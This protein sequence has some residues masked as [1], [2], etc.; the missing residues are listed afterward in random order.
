MELTEPDSSVAV[1]AVQDTEAPV[2]LAAAR[3]VMAP[4]GQFEMVGGLTSP[5]AV[6]Q[7]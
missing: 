4:A 3:A 5:P 2:E 7:R 6:R 1:G